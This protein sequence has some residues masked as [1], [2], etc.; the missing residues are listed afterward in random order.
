MSAITHNHTKLQDKHANRRSHRTCVAG[1]G[2][3]CR[4]RGWIG[5]GGRRT[6]SRIGASGFVHR[7]LAVSHIA[8]SD[9]LVYVIVFGFHSSPIDKEFNIHLRAFELIIV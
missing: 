1:R 5:A 6:H 9:V 8:I 2:R 7:H 4:A 3:A